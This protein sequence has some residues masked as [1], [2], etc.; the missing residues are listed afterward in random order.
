MF[1]CVST[2]LFSWFSVPKHSICFPCLCLDHQWA[3][4]VAQWE[5]IWRHRCGLSPCIG[6]PWK[7]TRQPTLVFLPG[8]PHGQRSL[9][10]H[11]P[12]DHKE[13][14]TTERLSMSRWLMIIQVT[15]LWPPSWP[16][17]SAQHSC[18]SLPGGIHDTLALPL[19]PLHL[20]ASD[21]A[22]CPHPPPLRAGPFFSPPTSSP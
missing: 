13:S 7:R 19:L 2:T 18:H 4:Q 22:S 10:G 21:S 1:H 16:I 5:R 12:W 3:S 9:V 11:S 17:Y 14:D 20:R 6:I 8:E 15:C